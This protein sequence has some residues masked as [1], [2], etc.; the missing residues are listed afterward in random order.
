MLFDLLRTALH[1]AETLADVVVKKTIDKFPPIHA[2]L[3][4]EFE[5]AYCD[6][7]VDFV[8]VLVVK[9]RVACKHLEKQ[10]A[11]RPPVHRMVVS[12]T[13]DDLWSEVLGRA[14]KHESSV[15]N[16]LGK[17]KVRNSHVTVGSNQQVFR[18]DITISNLHRVQVLECSNDLR[19]IEQCNIVREQVLSPQQSKNLATLHILKREVNV[20]FVL[21]RFMA[22]IGVRG[23]AILTG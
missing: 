8:W 11:Q 20:S 14:A 12:H 4:W 18:F 15:L 3:G 21:E 10:D 17:S 6:F 1:A 13:H 2:D 23:A 22:K 5:V 7:S 19:H 16:L 9:G